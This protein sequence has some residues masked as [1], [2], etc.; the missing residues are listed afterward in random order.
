MAIRTY[1]NGDAHTNI[2]RNTKVD[3]QNK[4]TGTHQH[5]NHT[6]KE[7]D[8]GW[9]REKG[10]RREERSEVRVERKGR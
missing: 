10:E 3:R 8:R 7:R 6:D 4:D 5:I 9:N 1:I 2:Y